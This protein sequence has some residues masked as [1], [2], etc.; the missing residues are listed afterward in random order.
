MVSI[1]IFNNKGGVGKTTLLCNL[2]AF[3]SLEKRKKV[4]VVDADPQCN[5]SSYILGNDKLFDVYTE[6][7]NN[8]ILK[9]IECISEGESYLSRID[10]P[11]NNIGNNF[12]VDI[13]IGDTSLSAKEDFLSADWIQGKNAEPRGLKTTMVFKDM[14]LKIA[15]DYDYVFFDVGPS[16]GA[17]N[18]TVLLACDYFIMPMSSDIFSLKAIDNIS[19]TLKGWKSSFDKGL[20]EYKEN[21]GKDYKIGDIQAECNLKFLGYINQQ[22][23]AKRVNDERRPVKAYD[24]I[25][26]QIPNKV[27]SEFKDLI[28][29][30]I[31]DSLL[32]GEI[33]TFSS[34]VP[35]SQTVNKPIFKLDGND[36]VV[37]AHFKKVVEFRS[38]IEKVANNVE[39]NLLLL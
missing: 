10:L 20:A 35:M 15:E 38:V 2:S 22:Y 14:L 30:S 12:G 27:S 23:T 5:A 24:S 16:L 25:L 4:L 6:Q 17:I 37:G 32:I 28:S 13:I 19:V 34:L 8:T 36:G 33:P 7:P 3:F 1:A 31:K 18:R 29:T 39:N 11:I 21:K 26:Q 9:I